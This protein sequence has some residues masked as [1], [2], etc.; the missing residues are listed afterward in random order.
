[1]S[2]TWNSYPNIPFMGVL[3]CGIANFG[4]QTQV[5][6]IDDSLFA[7]TNPYLKLNPIAMAMMNR[8]AATN[9]AYPQVNVP[10]QEQIQAQVDEIAGGIVNNINNG[11]ARQSLTQS[12][13]S[14]NVQKTKLNSMLADPN[15][16]DAQKAE[17][18]R[19]L[20]AIQQQE[21]KLAEL[22][23]NMAN[24]DSK[25]ALDQ[26]HAIEN[27]IRKIVEATAKINSSDGTQQTQQSEQTGQTEQA[28]A[29]GGSESQGGV[30]QT[31]STQSAQSARCKITEEHRMLADL[32][33]DAVTGPGTG[34]DF[35][36]VCRVLTKDNVVEVMMA[37]EEAYGKSLMEDF[38]WDA[39]SGFCCAGGQKVSYGRHIARILRAR[40]L[41]SGVYNDC[42]EDIVAINKEMDSFWYVSNDIS[43]N[44]D[45]VAAIIAAKDN[46]A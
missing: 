34:D 39:N 28:Q 35:D 18:N 45:N 43:Q 42:K 26:A 23:Q 6:T 9:S 29:T 31:S 7:A 24:M 8:K 10:S 37:Y 17:V 12:A 19:L 33:H 41:E 14:L 2:Y 1:M 46:V 44:Y 36:E 30:Q 32:F 15:L 38:M 4:G 11:I 3:P 16:S 27:D 13:T 5:F 20:D 21:Q 22:S 25:E 40:A